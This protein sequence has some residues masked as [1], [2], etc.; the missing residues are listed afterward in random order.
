MAPRKLVD[1]I[2]PEP[3][4]EKA[5]KEFV[6]KLDPSAK[7]QERFKADCPLP[8]ISA[9]VPITTRCRLELATK[10]KQAS[11]QR[12]L[13]GE[14]PFYVQDIMEEALHRWLTDHGF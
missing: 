13:N 8:Q 9:R 6:Y 14:S 2:K 4:T 1:G 12:Q 10:L 11:L 7:H 5:E 3:A